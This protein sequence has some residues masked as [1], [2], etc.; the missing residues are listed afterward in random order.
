MGE[1]F[2]NHGRN[3]W[4][5]GFAIIAVPHASSCPFDTETVG[6]VFL[7]AGHY[8]IRQVSGCVTGYACI[9]FAIVEVGGI[10]AQCANQGIFFGETGITM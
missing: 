7:Q 4:Q 3:G 5:T 6:Q 10:N 1:Q 2:Q 8:H 9:Q